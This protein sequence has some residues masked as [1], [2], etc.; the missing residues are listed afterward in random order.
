MNIPQS[1]L[2]GSIT[3]PYNSNNEVLRNDH[4]MFNPPS[5]EEESIYNDPDDHNTDIKEVH[6]DNSEEGDEE[7]SY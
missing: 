5:H 3:Q 7:S 1:S 4:N 2:G 6:G